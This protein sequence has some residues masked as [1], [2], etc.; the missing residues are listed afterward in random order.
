MRYSVTPYYG[1]LIDT[2]ACRNVLGDDDF[3]PVNGMDIVKAILLFP[4]V[5]WVCVMLMFGLFVV[6]RVIC[7]FGL[8]D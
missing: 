3:L 5:L 2:Y 7:W 1:G 8:R 4:F 6:F